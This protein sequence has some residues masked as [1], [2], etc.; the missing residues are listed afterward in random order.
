[1]NGHLAAA[2]G[3]AP[4]PDQKHSEFLRHLR[5]LAR[6]ARRGGGGG[7]AAGGGLRRGP[8][9]EGDHALEGVGD[10]GG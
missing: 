8:G 6:P 7:R 3:G 9:V 5:R 4:H 1:M 10:V 2:L